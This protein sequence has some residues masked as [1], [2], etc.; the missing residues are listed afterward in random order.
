MTYD[1]AKF[2]NSNQF[3]SWENYANFKDTDQ[4]MSV[5]DKFL[6]MEGMGGGGEGVAPPQT[7]SEFAQQ[8][9]APVQQKFQNLS[10]AAT[11]LGQGN[12]MNAYNAAQGKYQPP[13]TPTVK[14]PAPVTEHGYDANW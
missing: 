11:Q 8:A 10:N 2:V 9:I 1:P 12:A 5:K 4:M 3:G 7:M 13:T 6:Q 14:P